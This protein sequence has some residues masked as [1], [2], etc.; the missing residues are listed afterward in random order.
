MP[1]TTGRGTYR[2]TKAH[3]NPGRGKPRPKP[4]PRTLKGPTS[5][6]VPT[7]TLGVKHLLG[8]PQKPGKRTAAQQMKNIK[9]PHTGAFANRKKR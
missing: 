1:H 3:P 4:K 6:G 5:G 7:G 2:S 9:N 8:S